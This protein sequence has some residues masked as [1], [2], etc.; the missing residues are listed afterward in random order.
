MII[1]TL[2]YG[3]LYLKY[4]YWHY[5]NVYLY[6]NSEIDDKYEDCY[7]VCSKYIF[8]YKKQFI[9]YLVIYIMNLQEQLI[10]DDGLN[11]IEISA[12]IS[13]NEYHYKNRLTNEYFEYDKYNIEIMYLFLKELYHSLEKYNFL[14]EQ[15][16]YNLLYKY[17]SYYEQSNRIS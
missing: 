14:T 9:D 16:V 11:E 8:G 1:S 17:R 13:L 12:L 4:L 2:N 15:E 5:R 7:D 10:K 6:Y 3:L